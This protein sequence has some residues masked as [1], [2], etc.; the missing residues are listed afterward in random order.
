[1]PIERCP[2]FDDEDHDNLKEAHQ[3]LMSRCKSHLVNQVSLKWSSPENLF[4]EVSIVSIPWS[5]EVLQSILLS[6]LQWGK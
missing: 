4:G 2:L 3:Y 1:M 6:P 5:N